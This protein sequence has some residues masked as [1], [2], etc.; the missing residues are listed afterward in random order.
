MPADDMVLNQTNRHEEMS[1]KIIQC[2]GLDIHLQLAVSFVIIGIHHNLERLLFFQS[3]G[4]RGIDLRLVER[5]PFSQCHMID[6]KQGVG[7]IVV[8]PF[9]AFVGEEIGETAQRL[10]QVSC[11]DAHDEDMILIQLMLQVMGMLSSG[12]AVD[13]TGSCEVL[14]KHRLARR[15]HIAAFQ[16]DRHRINCRC[17]ILGGHGIGHG[18]GEIL[19]HT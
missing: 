15:L 14:D 12:G 5:V 16:I 10:S 8:I 7:V 2:D 4:H 13:A 11:M 17:A 19:S 1:I 18:V 3:S 6:S 9:G